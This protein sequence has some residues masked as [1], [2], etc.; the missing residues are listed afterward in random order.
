MIFLVGYL[1]GLPFA[2]TAMGIGAERYFK[3]ESLDDQEKTITAIVA[4]IMALLWPIVMAGCVLAAP[5]I[6]GQKLVKGL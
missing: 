4:F 1:I 6:F 5:F 3:Q 2:L